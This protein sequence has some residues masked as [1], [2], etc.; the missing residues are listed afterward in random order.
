MFGLV[1]V[2]QAAAYLVLNGHV[3]P[4]RLVSRKMTWISPHALQV[5]FSPEHG[6]FLWT[7][8]A[9]LGLVGLAGQVWRPRIGV[10]GRHGE[11]SGPAPGEAEGDSRR[12]AICLLAMVLSQVYVAGCVE[13]WT[14]AGAFGQRRF[15]GLTP[16]LVAGLTWLLAAARRRVSRVA[17]ASLL[18]LSVWWNLGLI[19]QFGA[20]L[21]DRQRLELARNAYTNFVVLPRMLPGY[22]YRYLFERESFYRGPAVSAPSR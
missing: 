13:S 5:L 16:L 11:P 7:P 17:L 3:G 21:M 18:A 8:L 1:F 14:V 4:S 20:G 6:L 10:T 19:V 9:A 15:V 12:L 22:A 2:P